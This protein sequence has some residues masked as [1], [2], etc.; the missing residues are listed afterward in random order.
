M[1]TDCS[2]C[3]TDRE[4]YQHSL[5]LQGALIKLHHCLFLLVSFDRAL[6]H[7]ADLGDGFDPGYFQFFHQVA[8]QHGSS[9]SVAVHAVDSNTL[10]GPNIQLWHSISSLGWSLFSHHVRLKVLVRHPS[11]AGFQTADYPPRPW[12]SPLQR[13]WGISQSDSARGE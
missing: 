7:C 12:R 4:S 11:D 6:S 8:G 10:E 2:T 3:L 1:Q 9:P 13:Y 5:T